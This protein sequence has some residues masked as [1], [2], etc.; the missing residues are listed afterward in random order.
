MY[1]SRPYSS[2]TKD[3]EKKAQPYEVKTSKLFGYDTFSGGT[4]GGGGLKSAYEQKIMGRNSNATKT[5]P[6][7]KDEKGFL[8]N[9]RPN[10]ANT[11][12]EIKKP[13]P[14]PFGSLAGRE[15]MMVTGSSGMGPSSIGKKKYGTSGSASRH[16]PKY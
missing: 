10:S 4:G 9:D 8:A 12:E 15:E 1:N 14:M 16:V 13:K 3:R 7:K 2:D 5:A 6:R 11:S